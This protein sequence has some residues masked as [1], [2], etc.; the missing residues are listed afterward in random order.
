M[1]FKDFV[2]SGDTGI[3]GAINTLVIP[4][5]IALAFVA[6]VWGVVN[7]FF[8]NG[9]DE[10]SREEGKQ[11]ILYGVLGLAVLLSVWGLVNMLLSTLGIL[12]T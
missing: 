12:P 4:V 2:G 1:T 11:F 7:Y 3:I 5:I 8:I 9:E 6:F 10:G